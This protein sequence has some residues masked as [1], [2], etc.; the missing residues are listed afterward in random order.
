M[1]D[2]RNGAATRPE[3]AIV[4]IALRPRE[5]AAA[6][7]VSRRTLSTLTAD[8]ESGIPHVR[9]GGCLLYPSRELQDW[10]ASRVK[11]PR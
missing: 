8:R 3:V 5:A 6:L 4:P 2:D 10:L 11:R 1:S 9:L 7:G